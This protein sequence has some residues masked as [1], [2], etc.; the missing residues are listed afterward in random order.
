[1]EGYQDPD[2]FRT[3]VNACIQAL[4]NSTFVLQSEKDRIDDFEAWY[5]PWRE[6][7]KADPVMHWLHDARTKVVHRGD[8]ETE[9]RLRVRLIA[10]YDDA[11]A[12]LESGLPDPNLEMELEPLA[13]MAEALE[14][15]S[16]LSIP[17]R[18]LKQA[19]LSVE[20]R[21]LTENCLAPNC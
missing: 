6:V 7:M 11:T 13:S 10:T 15:V 20:R 14:K 4:R 16:R 8:L 12:E 18:V 21:W 17:E 3:Q 19:T 5:E 1:M 2:E 9:S